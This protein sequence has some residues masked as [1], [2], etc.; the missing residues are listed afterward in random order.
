MLVTVTEGEQTSVTELAKKAWATLEAGRRQHLE[1]RVLVLLAT[2][3]KL[4]S[5]DKLG[6]RIVL[7]IR[8][9]SG[10]HDDGD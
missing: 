4:E 5:L 9:P 7:Y 2:Q 3:R 1:R 10:G 8:R 6:A